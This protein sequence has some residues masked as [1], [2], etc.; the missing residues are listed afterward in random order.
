VKITPFDSDF[1]IDEF[2]L[3][4]EVFDRGYYQLSYDPEVESLSVL[5]EEVNDII[6]YQYLVVQVTE[7]YLVLFPNVPIGKYVVTWMI[8]G[9]SSSS[10][11]SAP[12]PCAETNP[13]E[14]LLGTA[15]PVFQQNIGK[16]VQ[17]RYISQS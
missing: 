5:I 12:D 6:Y 1:K 16:T 4:T 17:I 7:E 15:Y 9:S 8:L 10:S 2:V 14:D 3:T 11:S 13:L